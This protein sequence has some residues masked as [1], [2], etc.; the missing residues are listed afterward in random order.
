MPGVLENIFSAINSIEVNTVGSIYKLFL[1][2]LLGAVVGYERKR[3]GQSA[4]VRTFSLISMG[5]TLAMLLSIYV[6]QEYMGLKNG[7]P[8]RIAAQVITGIGFLGAGAIIQMKGSVRGLTT[9]AGIW[10]VAI[11][12]MAVGLGMYWL[13]IVASALI[14][15]VLVLLE[16][17]ELKVSRGSESRIIRIRTADIL[18]GISDYK[19]VL[20]HNHI[21]L[22]NFYVDYDYDACETRLNLIVLVRESTDYIHLFSQFAKL[23]PTKS[24]TLANQLSI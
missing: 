8:G 7:D 15:F 23:H 16:K 24:I 5:A 20:S 1:S 18:E 2:M 12:G 22:Q 13:S 4:G 9:A 14:I 11:I 19:L 3:K 10:M 21:Q 17:I 6:P